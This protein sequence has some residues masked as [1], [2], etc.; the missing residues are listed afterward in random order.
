MGNKAEGIF[1]GVCVVVCGC[2][3]VCV[4]E[5]MMDDDEVVMVMDG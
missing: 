1:F 5:M 4:D 3:C 2:V